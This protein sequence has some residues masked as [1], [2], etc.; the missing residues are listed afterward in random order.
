[1]SD[2]SKNK[3]KW[4]IS[5]YSLIIYVLVTNKFTYSITNLLRFLSQK[6]NTLDENGCPTVFGYVL[7]MLVFFLLVRLLMEIK[8][9][10]VDEKNE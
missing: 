9:P 1:M 4:I 5:A 6:L 2:V 8:L 3:E 7:H 10:G